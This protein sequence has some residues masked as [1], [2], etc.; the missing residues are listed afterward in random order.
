M[1]DLSPDLARL[2]VQFGN[3]EML[4]E[5]RQCSRSNEGTATAVTK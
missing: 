5:L 4:W 2:K 1:P 3:H